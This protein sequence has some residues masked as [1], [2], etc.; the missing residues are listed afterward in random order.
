MLNTMRV[1]Y[2]EDD[3]DVRTLMTQR[4]KRHVGEL[5]IAANGQQGLALYEAEKPDLV[6]TDVQM[7]EMDGLA[8]ARAIKA[9]NHETPIIVTTAYSDA[10]Y[11]LHAI[12]CGVD[13]YVVK[14]IK[15]DMLLETLSKHARILFNQHEVARQNQEL[16]RLY[17]MDR[18]DHAIA[19]AILHKMMQSDGLNDP[20]IRCYLKPTQEFSGDFIAAARA[21]NGDLF[22]MLADVT[23]HGLQAA[24]FLLPISRVFYSMV[25]RGRSISQISAEMNR[26]MKEYSVAGRF[27]AAALVRL[28][29]ECLEIWSGGMPTALYIGDDGRILREFPSS[30]PPLGIFSPQEFDSGT[31]T[32]RWSSPG[33]LFLTSDGL[34]DAENAQGE[35]F[36]LNRLKDT[37]CGASSAL[38]MQNLI[39]HIDQHLAGNRAHDDMSCVLM[40]CGQIENIA[41]P[42]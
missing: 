41:S 11:L 5:I 7:P 42:P 25:K 22:A 2:V 15:V 10:D 14:P 26:T 18:Q 6:I 21:G 20:N 17:E 12:N 27:I 28:D 38:R 1:L 3:E 29:Q 33:T 9:I 34:I 8:M 13:D 23:G 35:A 32:Y 19:N 16:Q 36:G 4:L 24:V 40:F 37:L 39:D 31:E 30:H